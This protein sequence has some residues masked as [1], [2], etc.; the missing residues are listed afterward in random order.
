[1]H[2][3]FNQSINQFISRHSTEARAT[4]RLCQINTE[5]SKTSRVAKTAAIL[6]G[7]INTKPI[8]MTVQNVRT[9]YNTEQFW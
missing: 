7:T 6:T 8:L 5:N 9:Q 2:L 4:V 1:V 3:Y